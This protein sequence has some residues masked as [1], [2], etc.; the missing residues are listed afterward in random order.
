MNAVELHSHVACSPRRR[1]SRSSSGLAR[2]LRTTLWATA[3]LVCMAL[4][5]LALAAN[6]E[7]C[8]RYKYDSPDRAYGDF[9]TAQYWNGRGLKLIVHVGGS[10]PYLQ[11]EANRTTGCFSFTS[12]LTSNMTAWVGRSAV[13][14]KTGQLTEV[15]LLNGDEVMPVTQFSDI[16]PTAD[17]NG[18]YRATLTLDTGDLHQEESLAAIAYTFHTTINSDTHTG[19]LPP[20]FFIKQLSAGNINNAAASDDY[21]RAGNPFRPEKF[22]MAHEAGHSLSWNIGDPEASSSIYYNYSF[23]SPS[24]PYTVSEYCRWDEDG[25]PLTLTSAHAMRSQEFSATALNEGFAHFVSTIMWNDR[26]GTDGW[27]KYY[28]TNP[29]FGYAAEP[30]PL[31]EASYWAYDW[32]HESPEGCACADPVRANCSGTGDT[33]DWL[34]ALWAWGSGTGTRPTISQIFRTYHLAFHEC[35]PDEL[36]N[37]SGR[38]REGLYT[39]SNS[40]GFR[41]DVRSAPFGVDTSPGSESATCQ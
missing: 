10:V 38:F 33:L 41:W 39:I 13:I 14:G 9:G 24:H 2:L 21:I 40:Q 19:A 23:P 11:V 30:Y 31:H 20:Q 4:P 34:R 32:L 37:A 6:H 15:I 18:T 35:A 17:P 26:T 22:L 8:V 3:M 25:D 5:S 1:W 27:Y 28:K 29:F 7:W 16:N 12:S 36:T